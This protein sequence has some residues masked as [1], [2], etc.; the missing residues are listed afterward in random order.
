MYWLIEVL[1]EAA[2]TQ[3]ESL[4]EVVDYARRLPTPAIEWI[5]N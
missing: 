4:T 1:K 3:A 5:G 2:L